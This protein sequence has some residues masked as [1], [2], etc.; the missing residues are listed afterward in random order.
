M[1][2]KTKAKPAQTAKAAAETL[3]GAETSSN[4]VPF[5]NRGAVA[6]P[7]GFKTKRM[8]TMPSLSLKDDE[9]RALLIVDAI[10][11]SKVVD[12]SP[13]KRE[14]ANICSVSDVE[15]G[16]AFTFLVPK[17][18]QANLERDYPNEGYVGLTFYVENLG[19]R[20]E[21]QRYNDFRIV[22]LEAD[23]SE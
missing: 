21:S 15:T 23:A 17:V 12:K 6:L 13:Q 3:Q 2:A 7:A 1:N 11:V 22:E 18:V 20:T 9:G 16:E 4:V 14:P 8:V 10:R 19:K 5:V